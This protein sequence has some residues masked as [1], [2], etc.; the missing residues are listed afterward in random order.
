V[1]SE[2]EQVIQTAIEASSGRL[3]VIVGVSH[4]GTEATIQLSKKAESLGAHAVLVA[5]IKEAVPDQQRIFEFYQ[6]L[7]GRITIPICIHDYPVST[8]VYLPVPLLLRIVE[9]IPA[10]AAIKVEAVPSAAKIAA[11]IQGMK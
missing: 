6:R 3:P 10:V 4:T 9:Q 5:P 11:L 8:G 1:E 2:R 7:A